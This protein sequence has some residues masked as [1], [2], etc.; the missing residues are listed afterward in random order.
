MFSVGLDTSA[1]DAEFKAHAMRGTGRY[2]SE[3]SRYFREYPD[4]DISICTFS[5]AELLERSRLA[6]LSSCLPAGK[7]TFRQ[8]LA[9]PLALS[10]E[11]LQGVD[12]L[13]FPA[14]VDAPTWSSKRTI[15]TVLDL[16]PV[17][18]ADLYAPEKH[19]WRFRLA[20]WLE[21]R[22]I[23]HAELIL[24]ISEHTAHDVH[25]VLGIP[26]EKIVV[27]PLGVDG[28]FFEPAPVEAMFQKYPLPHNRPIVLYVGGIDQRKNIGVMFQAFRGLIEACVEQ[29][30]AEPILALAG[31][32]RS[33][34]E[35]DNLCALRRQF[36]LDEH[37]VELGFVPDE[38]LPAIYQAA[39]V[40]FFPSLYEGFG[41]PPL[42]A[43]ASGTPVVS[44]SAS[45]LPEVLGDAGLLFAAKDIRAATEQLLSVLSKSEL[46][47][48][49]SNIGRER[50]QQFTWD[51]TAR[52]TRE[53]YL[54]LA[55]S[56]N[57]MTHKVAA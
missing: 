22:A 23:S 10:G 19:S 33:D 39:D 5:H 15:V 11:K 34:K 48:D 53:A 26:R 13:H 55:H 35:Y 12:V 28:R 38:D 49:L 42:E 50:A 56:Q 8:Q 24:A 47:A 16:I 31:N 2:V 7:V 20:R 40:F 57:R 3:L 45:C 37:V 27:T 18:L 32:I 46:A 6:A 43:M 9:Y 4:D 1:L 41:L 52:L 14:H 29:G 30:M 36:S 44:S 54:R 17:V 21:L 51:Q 25:R